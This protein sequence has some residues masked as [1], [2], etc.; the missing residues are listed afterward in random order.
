MAI[1]T[2]EQAARRWGVDQQ[3]V[4]MELREGRLRGYRD[5]A[6]RWWIDTAEPS[7]NAEQRPTGVPVAEV[8]R[9][10][11]QIETMSAEI[12]EL[13]Q[14]LEASKR[15]IA[16]LKERLESPPPRAEG[17]SSHWRPWRK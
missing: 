1:L 15:S 11:T 5:T 17:G 16:E 3:A 2:I 12:A 7:S 14:E 13:R 8:R 4:Q 9:L 10:G 6:G